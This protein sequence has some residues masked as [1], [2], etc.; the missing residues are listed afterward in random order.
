[1]NCLQPEK[2][3]CTLKD[4]VIFPEKSG[5]EEWE[6]EMPS[7]TRYGRQRLNTYVISEENH[8]KTMQVKKLRVKVTQ[9]CPTLCDTMDSIVHGILQY[10]IL[11]F[12]L[13]LLWGIFPT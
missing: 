8:Q 4:E 5:M 13:S 2:T 9:S 1:M 10:R 7:I 3:M 11:E 6:K 12:S